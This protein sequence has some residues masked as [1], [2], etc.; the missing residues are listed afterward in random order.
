MSPDAR[1]E[2]VKLPQIDVYYV[3]RKRPARRLRVQVVQPGAPAQR[4][5]IGVLAH[6]GDRTDGRFYSIDLARFWGIWR[7]PEE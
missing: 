1:I 4:E 7:D 2:G 6:E 5:V 3:D